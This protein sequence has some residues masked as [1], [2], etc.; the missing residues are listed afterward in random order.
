MDQPVKSEVRNFSNE[1]L[2]MV[3]ISALI[4]RAKEQC[5]YEGKGQLAW[6]SV[7]SMFKAPRIR[8]KPSSM[9]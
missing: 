9:K 6:H 2:F 8:A 3:A 7:K 5:R 4:R 1:N